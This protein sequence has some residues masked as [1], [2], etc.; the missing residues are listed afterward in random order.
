MSLLSG[1]IQ[2]LQQNSQIWEHL[3]RARVHLFLPKLLNLLRRL[4]I[5][6]AQ[7]RKGRVSRDE[8]PRGCFLFGE[9]L[10]ERANALD[11]R[12][13]LF[14]HASLLAAAILIT[15]FGA[16]SRAVVAAVARTER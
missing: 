13:V 12:G 3:D 10:Q 16:P 7:G 2:N 11:H 1:R 4:T 8:V 15:A 9:P 14:G 6:P 5:L